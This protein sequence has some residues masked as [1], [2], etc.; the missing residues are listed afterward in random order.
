MWNRWRWVLPL[1]GLT[2][3]GVES[4]H[5]YRLNEQLG[6]NPRRYYWWSGIRLD[7]RPTRTTRESS[8]S[9]QPETKDCTFQLDFVWVDPGY[10]TQLLTYSALPA[11]AAEWVILVVAERFGVGQVWTFMLTMPVLI[12]GWFCLVGWLIDLWILRR[13]LPRSSTA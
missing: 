7:S 6:A 9:C 3:F 5:S 11:F 2:L 4:Y 12:A 10:A 13:S 1:I 8:P